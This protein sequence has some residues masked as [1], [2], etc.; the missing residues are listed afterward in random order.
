MTA[1]DFAIAARTGTALSDVLR[2]PADEW[3]AWATHLEADLSGSRGVQTLLAKRIAQAAS[4]P[5]AL[6][7]YRDVAPWLSPGHLER[8]ERRRLASLPKALRGQPR[9]A[10]DEYM[11]RRGIA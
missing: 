3:M 9:A 6:V 5:G 10:Q 11:R 4:A 2:L 8:R 7:D 1:R